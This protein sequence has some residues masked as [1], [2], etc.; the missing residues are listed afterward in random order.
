MGYRVLHCRMGWRSAL[1]LQLPSPLS[2][3]AAESIGA[4]TCLGCHPVALSQEAHRTEER[5]RQLG[6]RHDSRSRR[7]T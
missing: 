2:T 7:R 3:V 4:L 1:G 5:Y 6:L